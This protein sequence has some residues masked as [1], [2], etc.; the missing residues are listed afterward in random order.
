M[1]NLTHLMSLQELLKINLSKQEPVLLTDIDDPP[2]VS[3]AYSTA[4]R[5]YSRAVP[6]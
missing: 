6:V 3:V 1:E 2:V 5:E 4:W